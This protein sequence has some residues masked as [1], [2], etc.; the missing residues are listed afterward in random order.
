MDSRADDIAPQRVTRD[1]ALVMAVAV[2]VLLSVVAWY[3]NV[4]R[5]TTNG[6][7]RSMEVRLFV[8]EVPNRRT[9]PGNMLYLPAIGALVSMLPEQ[10]GPVWRRM[11]FVNAMFGALV[12]ALTYAIALRLF[13]SRGAAL[14]TCLSMLSSAF[15][16][17]LSTINEDI[18]PGYAWFV[19]ALTCL[20]L[21]Q[22]RDRLVLF[23]GAQCVAL[24][25]LFHS[26]L[27]PPTVGAFVL[28]IL[29][30]TRPLAEGVRRTALFV[31]S[32]IPVSMISAVISGL[33]WWR[34]LWSGKGLDTGWVGLLPAKFVFMWGG[35][36]QAVAGGR[37]IGSVED[38]LARATGM[39]VTWVVLAIVAAAAS[40]LWYR[41]RSRSSWQLAGVILASTFLLGEAMNLYIQPQDPQMQLQPMTWFAFACGAVYWSLDGLRGW[42]KPVAR[43]ALVVA[44]CLLLVGNLRV[45]AADRHADSTAI[46]NIA[47]LEEMA[48][49]ADTVFLMHGFEGLATWLSATWG[50]GDVWPERAATQPDDVPFD[51]R[52]ANFKP[53]YVAGEA[54]AFPGRSPLEASDDIVRL[55]ERALDAGYA[56][57]ATDIWGASVDQWV[58][59]FSTVSGPDM[60]IAIRRALHD[61]FTA[62]EIG[63]LPRWGRFYHLARRPPGV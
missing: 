12:L 9:T 53:I 45:Y 41:Q 60:P 8:D 19:A 3:D 7:W 48:P 57:V 37:N 51:V 47:R 54:T 6:L 13:Q 25:F 30:S 38:V 4:H 35:I 24:S 31:G 22:Q 32:L 62:T 29:A 10:L 50:V 56:V 27:Q 52:D 49:R 58:A 28:G 43:G 40:F 18:M 55:V 46:V 17:L 2:L 34:G 44:V 59:S 33:P 14:F 11:A 63:H 20:V 21:P 26:S 23:I 36:A 42:T 39:A 16:L 61:R 5:A 1:A 15:F